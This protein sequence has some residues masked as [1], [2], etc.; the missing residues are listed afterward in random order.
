MNFI[1]ELDNICYFAEKGYL[2][3]GKCPLMDLT[4]LKKRCPLGRKMSSYEPT[5]R[6]SETPQKGYLN[7]K[8][9]FIY[10][11]NIDKY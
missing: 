5:K 3:F 6:V 7:Q 4:W 8:I 10:S 11:K 2:W 9:I 1:L